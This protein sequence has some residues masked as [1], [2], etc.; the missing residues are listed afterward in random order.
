M[1]LD[2]GVLNFLSSKIFSHQLLKSLILI[3]IIG[4]STSTSR[5]VQWSMLIR[6]HFSLLT[7]GCPFHHAPDFWCIF[8]QLIIFQNSNNFFQISEIRTGLFDF[9]IDESPESAFL[10]I[11]DW[12]TMTSTIY[13][14]ANPIKRYNQACA[15]VKSNNETIQLAMTGGAGKFGHDLLNIDLYTG[16]ESSWSE[17]SEK[18][19]MESYESQGLSY[20]QLLS[21]K[22][23]SELLLYGGQIGD[24]IFDGIYKYLSASNT[25]LQV[26]KMMFPRAAHVVVPVQGL[27]C[28]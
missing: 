26:G 13:E 7:A 9:P 17:S 15:V 24:Q 11:I 5:K 21:I 22:N 4:W 1:Q 23:G 14:I 19:P 20:S 25:W 27:S 12:S 2:L 16:L 8:K 18:L 28:P 3:D 10:N 6:L